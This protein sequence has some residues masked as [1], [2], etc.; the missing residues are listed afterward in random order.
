MDIVDEH[1][2]MIFMNWA[3]TVAEQLGALNTQ[4]VYP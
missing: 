1:T 3:T 4:A 2:L